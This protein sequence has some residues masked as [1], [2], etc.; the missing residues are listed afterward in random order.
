[1]KFIKYLYFRLRGYTLT[2]PDRLSR[3]TKLLEPLSHPPRESLSDEQRP[4]VKMPCDITFDAHKCTH[5][6]ECVKCCQYNYISYQNPD[7]ITLGKVILAS[8]HDM[9]VDLFT[10][11]SAINASV[12]EKLFCECNDFDCVKVCRTG[13]ITKKETQFDSFL[14]DVIVLQEGDGPE[15]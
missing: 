5:C 6:M 13:A 9:F 3:I 14:D 7:G 12:E 10:S 4:H 2:D 11:F 15:T 8:E 1:M